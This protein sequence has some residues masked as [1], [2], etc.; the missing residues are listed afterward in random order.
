MHDCS[1]NVLEYQI[2]Q[3]CVSAIDVRIVLMDASLGKQTIDEIKQSLHQHIDCKELDITV[4]V[5]DTIN[6]T[7]SGKHKSIIAE[8]V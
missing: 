3:D 5:V 7:I 6:K 1:S 8:I 2:V 4:T